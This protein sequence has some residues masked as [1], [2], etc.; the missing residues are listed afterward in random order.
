MNS[1]ETFGENSLKI[2]SMSEL[3]TAIK[4]LERKRMLLEEDLKDEFHAVLE[5]LKPSNILKNT[6]HEV[7]E[8]TELKHNLFKVALGLGAG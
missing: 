3:T 6:I 2:A 5:S 8:S 4:R 7:Q 1:E